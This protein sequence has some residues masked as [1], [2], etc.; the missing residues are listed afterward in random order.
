MLQFTVELYL[1]DYGSYSYTDSIRHQ[2]QSEMWVK[3]DICLDW[4]LLCW[5]AG[6]V[7]LRC[8]IRF[9]CSHQAAVF[10]ILFII[11]PATIPSDN[12]GPHNSCDQT[13]TQQWRNINTFSS[14]LLLW[15][16]IRSTALVYFN[17]SSGSCCLLS[18]LPLYFPRIREFLIYSPNVGQINQL[19]PGKGNKNNMEYD[20]HVLVIPNLNL[21]FTNFSQQKPLLN[22]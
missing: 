18:A 1:H 3:T 21:N 20:H 15:D 13:T 14:L 12:P 7:Q 16:D 10:T 11:S 19:K 9:Y 6:V 17:L 8:F 4:L 5:E 2:Q 22:L